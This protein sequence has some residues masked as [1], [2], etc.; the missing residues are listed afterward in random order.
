MTAPFSLYCERCDEK[1]DTGEKG[2]L[3]HV[4]AS[5]IRQGRRIVRMQRMARGL[6]PRHAR[7]KIDDEV[8]VAIFRTVLDMSPRWMPSQ[9]TRMKDC[10]KVGRCRTCLAANEWTVVEELDQLISSVYFPYPVKAEVVAKVNTD[11]ASGSN[12]TLPYQ[13]H[14]DS[15]ADPH[16]P[17]VARAE[18][19]ARERP[20]EGDEPR[21]QAAV[22]LF[23]PHAHVGRS[24]RGNE[25]LRELQ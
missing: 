1:N 15:S 6:T 10:A 22:P 14:L 17:A 19:G 21:R 2:A 24:G 8:R 5:T 4:F 16:G 3:F 7:K 11:H 18:V 13:T 9:A 20:N 23:H 25:R 12:A